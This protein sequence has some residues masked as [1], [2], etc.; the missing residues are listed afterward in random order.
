MDAP[1][2]TK[3]NAVVAVQLERVQPRVDK[4]ITKIMSDKAMR[5]QKSD[6]RWR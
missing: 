6:A 5:E 3:M 4:C 2:G 1:L